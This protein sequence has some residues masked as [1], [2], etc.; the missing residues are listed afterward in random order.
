MCFL[1]LSGGAA[2]QQCHSLTGRFGPLWVTG[3]SA[4]TPHPPR[5]LWVQVS[6]LY[7]GLCSPPSLT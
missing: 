5:T 2:A 4:L 1:S 6:A 3:R 7:A